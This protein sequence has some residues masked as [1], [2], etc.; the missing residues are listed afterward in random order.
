MTEALFLYKN[1]R[2]KDEDI[3]G[4]EEFVDETEK[5]SEGTIINLKEVIIGDNEWNN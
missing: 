2:L 4:T 5:V 1:G 3:I